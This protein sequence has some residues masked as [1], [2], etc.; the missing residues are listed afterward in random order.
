MTNRDRSDLPKGGNLTISQIIDWAKPP[1]S[2]AGGQN[3]MDASRQWAK[4]PP[5]ERYLDMPSL[6]ASLEE[7][8]FNSDEFP[9][10]PLTL[11]TLQARYVKEGPLA[12]NLYAAEYGDVPAIFT[13]WS[14][15]Q[16][17]RV[18]RG[19]DLGWLR[20]M[21]AP[22][23][24][25]ALNASLKYRDHP[26]EKVKLLVQPPTDGSSVLRAVTGPEYGRI[27]DADVVR[28]LILL[29]EDRW[30]VPG[31]IAGRGMADA[32]TE[33]TKESTTLYASDRDV[34]VFLVDE[35]HPID[36]DGGSYF[37]GLIVSNSEVGDAKFRVQSFYLNKVCQNRIIWDAIGMRELKIRHSRLAPTKFLEQAVPAI[38]AYANASTRGVAEAFAKARTVTVGKTIEDAE[39][40]LRQE[41]FNQFESGLIPVLAE[42]A[43]G[44]GSSGD[45]TSIYDLLQGA[46]AYARE[47]VY[48]DGRVEFERRSG[49]LLDKYVS[50]N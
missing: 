43:D 41:G 30:V 29:L 20:D 21:P 45:P 11:E 10:V 32:Y 38:A 1:T 34:W 44:I 49:G 15:G 50:L 6:L 23:A 8:Q 14:M 48:A 4:R 42:R 47:L 16:Y 5:D 7:R 37:R 3:L 25:H 19:P 27:W 13:N 40:F 33:V 39:E 24:A 22:E 36:I 2:R 46:T 9:D 12:G 28:S 18:V 31:K 17:N 35:Q 26:G